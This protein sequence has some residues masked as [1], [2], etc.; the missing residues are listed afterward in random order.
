M[1]LSI[2]E[3]GQ[4]RHDDPDAAPEHAGADAR[5]DGPAVPKDRLR[6]QGP[7]SRFT[8]CFVVP[9]SHCELPD[10]IS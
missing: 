7:T 3:P 5:E 9:L 4:G 2:A 1:S 8:W 6:E 10:P